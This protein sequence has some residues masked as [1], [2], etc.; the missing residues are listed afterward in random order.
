MANHR[1]EESKVPR[2]GAPKQPFNTNN[3]VEEIRTEIV[4]SARLAAG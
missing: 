1:V 2:L 4:E 3:L